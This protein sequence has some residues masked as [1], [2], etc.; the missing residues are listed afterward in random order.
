[1]FRLDGSSEG[2][3]SNKTFDARV[4]MVRKKFPG[5]RNGGSRLGN[6]M[7]VALKSDVITRCN[8]SRATWRAKMGRML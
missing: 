3:S 6:A 1:M 5:V 2:G 8:F 7:T 4:E